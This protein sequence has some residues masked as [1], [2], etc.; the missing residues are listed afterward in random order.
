VLQPAKTRSS[1]VAE[2]KS[3]LV[4]FSLLIV[5]D[6]FGYLDNVPGNEIADEL[7][8]QAVL[9]PEP[10][11]GISS[12]TAQNTTLSWASEH[13]NLWKFTAGCRQAKM[14][15]QGPNKR[16]I[17]TLRWASVG[18]ICESLLVYLLVMLLLT[19]I[20]LTVMKICRSIV[21]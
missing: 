11:F 7:A 12:N 8:K 6:Y 19:D 2:T 16:L 10:V 21:K 5:Y 9:T 1:L 14:F 3:H 15:L 4:N 20:Y 13:R 18:N 17:D